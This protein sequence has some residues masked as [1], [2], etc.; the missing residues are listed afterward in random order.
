VKKLLETVPP[1]TTTDCENKEVAQSG[2]KT[3][4]L[5]DFDPLFEPYRSSTQHYPISKKDV[6]DFDSDITLSKYYI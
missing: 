1:E 5:F 3:V 2:L 6:R 4:N